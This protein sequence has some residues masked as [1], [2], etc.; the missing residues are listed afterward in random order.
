MDFK[1]DLELGKGE[2]TTNEEFFNS[3]KISVFGVVVTTCNAAGN[4]LFV[5]DS[6]ID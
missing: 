3:P 1:K 2:E 5:F 4:A 6:Y